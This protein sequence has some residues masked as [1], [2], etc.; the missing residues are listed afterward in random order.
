[1]LDGNDLSKKNISK[2]LE[3]GKT[4]GF[5]AARLFKLP[6][7]SH[8]FVVQSLEDVN[9]LLEQYPNQQQ[10]CMRSDTIIGDN[11]IGVGG[12]NGDRKTIFDYYDKISKENINKNS[13]GV[14]IIYW[15]DE[16]CQTHE[17][18]GVYYLGFKPGECLLIDYLGKGWDGSYLSHGS[19]VHECYTI[20]WN[21]I[22]E[23]KPT[24]RELYRDYLVSAEEY[25]RQRN[26]RIKD[27]IQKGIKPEIAKSAIPIEYR[28]ISN[29]TLEQINDNIILRM[30]LKADKLKRYKEY[31]TIVQVENGRIVVPEIILPERLKRKEKNYGGI[32]I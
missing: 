12:Q 6:T 24:K 17:I 21:Q 32:E 27:L 7:F 28:G 20:P 5:L 16:F 13:R 11:P 22:W 4:K 3:Y 25:T 23:F 2:M 1:M 31:I 10:F 14:A 30:Y 9:Q 18:N 15:N 26:I 8:F 29:S 19:A